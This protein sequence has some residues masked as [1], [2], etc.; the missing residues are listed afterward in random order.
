MPICQYGNHDV[1][2]MHELSHYE[3]QKNGVPF[4]GV[5]ICNKCL[6]EHVRQHYPGSGIEKHILLMHPELD[7]QR[8]PEDK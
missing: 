6:L 2:S 5:D 1:E 8:D 3:D 7:N 4:P